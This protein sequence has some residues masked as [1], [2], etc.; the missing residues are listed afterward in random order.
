M[1]KQLA[2]LDYCL[3]AKCEARPAQGFTSIGYEDLILV[4]KTK[5]PETYKR[6]LERSKLPLLTTRL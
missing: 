5:Y 4:L 1:L 6:L 2:K 3:C